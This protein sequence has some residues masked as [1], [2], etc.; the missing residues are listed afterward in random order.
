LQNS[1]DVDIFQTTKSV[2]PSAVEELYNT[3]EIKAF[4]KVATNQPVKQRLL[5]QNKL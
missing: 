2:I 1:F 4:L 5:K 3:L